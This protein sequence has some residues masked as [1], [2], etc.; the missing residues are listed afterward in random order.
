MRASTS[1]CRLPHNKGPKVKFSF[2]TSKRAYYQ[3][4]MRRSLSFK[5]PNKLALFPLKLF[6]LSKWLFWASLL[7]IQKPSTPRCEQYIALVLVEDL[8][9]RQRLFWRIVLIHTVTPDHRAITSVKFLRNF[10]LLS[11]LACAVSRTYTTP[12]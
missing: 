3:S 7:N 4:R 2:S 11:I 9:S 6:S 1:D 10:Q 8:V 5:L 12:Q